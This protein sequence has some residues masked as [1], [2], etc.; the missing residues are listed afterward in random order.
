MWKKVVYRDKRDGIIK[1]EWFKIK[2]SRS[3]SRLTLDKTSET[4]S[5]NFIKQK[6]ID[7]LGSFYKDNQQGETNGTRNSK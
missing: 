6:H 3:K 1:E 4:D 7:Y 5:I 2:G